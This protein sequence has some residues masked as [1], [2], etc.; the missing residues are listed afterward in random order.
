MKKKQKQFLKKFLVR[1][2][3]FIL[4]QNIFITYFEVYYYFI[5]AAFC[6]IIVR[7]KIFD[8]LNIYIYLVFLYIYVYD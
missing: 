2:F 8:L 6:R 5:Q 3:D 7:L 4:I 1:E